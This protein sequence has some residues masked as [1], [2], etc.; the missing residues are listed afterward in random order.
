MNICI[1]ILLSLS[2]LRLTNNGVNK[3]VETIQLNKHLFG[4]DATQLDSKEKKR[5]FLY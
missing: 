1:L 5:D 3:V 2:L 4:P